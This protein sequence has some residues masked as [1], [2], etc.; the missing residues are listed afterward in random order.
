M[1]TLKTTYGSIADPKF[2]LIAG[3]NCR[4]VGEDASL[5]VN[6]ICNSFMKYSYLLRVMFI[7]AAFSVLLA[8]MCAFCVGLRS[9]RIEQMA[10][11]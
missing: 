6:T 2:G 4:V 3:L 1:N 9:E 10:K 11:F 5:A 8:V 7:T